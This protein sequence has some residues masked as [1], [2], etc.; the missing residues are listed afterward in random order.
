MATNQ[1]QATLSD[2]G[3]LAELGERLARHRIDRGLTQARLADLA[4][5]GKRT[6]ERMESGASA[7]L[8]SFVRV[9]RVLGLINNLDLLIPER[10]PSPMQALEQKRKVRQRASEKS[11]PK[12]PDTAWSWGDES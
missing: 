10:E 3:V 11:E 8:S 6:V 5:V 2:E 9:L 12:R 1:L 4:G 7:Q